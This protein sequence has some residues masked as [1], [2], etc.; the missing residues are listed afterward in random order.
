METLESTLRQVHDWSVDRIHTLS[1]C[2]ISLESDD[3]GRLEKSDF[4]DKSLELLD[5]AFSIQQEFA[6]WLNPDISDHDILSLEYIG[7]DN[8]SC[9]L[10]TSPSP[11]D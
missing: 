10:Y 8:G 4:V 3:N 5:D 11:R 6:E 9:L 1:E 2:Y 7:D